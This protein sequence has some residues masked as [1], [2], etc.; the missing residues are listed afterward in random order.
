MGGGNNNDTKC[1]NE[2]KGTIDDQIV[3]NNHIFLNGD[4]HVTSLKQIMHFNGLHR[5][6]KTSLRIV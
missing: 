6:S 2:I 1:A 3:Q 5:K 4:K